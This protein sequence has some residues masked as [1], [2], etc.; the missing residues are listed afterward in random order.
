MCCCLRHWLG[1]AL[2]VTRCGVDPVSISPLL[3]RRSRPSSWSSSS[4]GTCALKCID[5]VFVLSSAPMFSACSGGW[6]GTAGINTGWVDLVKLAPVCGVCGASRC[7][8]LQVWCRPALAQEVLEFTGPVGPLERAPRRNGASTL[9]SQ[10]TACFTGGRVQRPG[11][12]K[13]KKVTQI[14]EQ[15]L[16]DTYKS[17]QRTQALADAHRQQFA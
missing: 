12:P 11:G 1:P 10:S 17:V 4:V 13:A 9:L 8:V 5:G 14:R 6:I 16:A 2:W 7:H 3:P 15:E